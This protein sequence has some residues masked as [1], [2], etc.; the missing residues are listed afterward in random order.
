MR[1]ID[2]DRFKAIINNA[3]TSMSM[4]E[5]KEDNVIKDIICKAIAL[6]IS[7]QPTID[8][9]PMEFLIGILKEHEENSEISNAIY[10]LIKKWSEKNGK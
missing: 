5:N 10:F 9:I 3:K 7:A 8:A 2:A 4:G 6:S 1:L